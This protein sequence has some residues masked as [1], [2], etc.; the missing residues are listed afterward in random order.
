MVGHLVDGHTRQLMDLEHTQNQKLLE[1]YTKYKDLQLKAQNMQEKCERQ[2]AEMEHTKARALEDLA[3][4]WEN[5]LLEVK[6]QLEGANTNAVEK[7]KEYQEIRRQIELD[8]DQEILA[9]KNQY[10]H[11][12]K[13]AQE[14]AMRLQGDNGIL[15][16]KYKTLA[17]DIEAAKSKREVMEAE[18]Q[19]LLAHIRALEKDISSGKKEIAERDETIQD[20]EKRIY[21]LKKKNQELEKFKFVLDYKI[22]ELKKQIEVCELSLPPPHLFCRL[23]MCSACLCTV[24]TDH[25]ANTC[26]CHIDLFSLVRTRSRRCELRLRRWTRSC[27]HTTIKRQN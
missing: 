16:K 25:L 19:K 8:A 14:T 12:L 1:E 9:L 24:L 5:K 17:R 13:E 22:K 21:D 7:Q 6:S 10:E 23:R 20:K 2:L 3:E 11:R 26:S 18:Q 4:F 27:R 15:R